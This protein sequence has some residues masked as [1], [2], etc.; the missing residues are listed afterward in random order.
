[1]AGSPLSPQSPYGLQAHT[2]QNDLRGDKPRGWSPK[3][4]TMKKLNVRSK[5]LPGESCLC[6]IYLPAF[7]AKEFF[8][9]FLLLIKL[10][11]QDRQHGE[12]YVST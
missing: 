8:L 12:I 10:P 4:E 11:L 6:A 7:K 2:P 1:M 5:S 3:D 9:F